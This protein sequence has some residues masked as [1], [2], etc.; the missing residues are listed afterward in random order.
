M[1]ETT[2]EYREHLD[3]DSENEDACEKALLS[4]KFQARLKNDDEQTSRMTPD[5]YMFYSECKTASFTHRKGKKFREWAEINKL[6]DMRANDDF[7][8][9]LGYL[10]FELLRKLTEAALVVAR[11]QLRH[12]AI[13]SGDASAVSREAGPIG[14]QDA[15][16]RYQKS[17]RAAAVTADQMLEG[18]RRLQQVRSCVALHRRYVGA[19]NPLAPLKRRPL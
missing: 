4:R 8:E 6:V 5:E 11:E 13:R 18:Y 19:S 9:V 1:W 10:C 3:D 15:L 17:G 12:A 16:V 14:A 7:V 2:K